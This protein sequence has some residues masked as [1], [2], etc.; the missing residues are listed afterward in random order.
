MKQLTLNFQTGME[1]TGEM[2]TSS[3][4][5]GSLDHASHSAQQ[6]NETERE[7]IATSG[8]KCY[9]S[10]ERLNRPGLLAKTLLASSRWTAGLYS[11]KYALRWK[12]KGTPSKRLYCQ[13]SVRERRTDGIGY[14]LLP[15]MSAS[16]DGRNVSTETHEWTGVYFKSKNGKKVQSDVRHIIENLYLLPTPKAADGEKGKGGPNGH[17]QTLGKAIEG[18]NGANTGMKLQPAFVEYLMG[19]P[20]GWTDLSGSKPSETP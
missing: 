6:E 7:M 3:S 1:P 4:P 15:T 12:L 18:T 19:Y 8:Q 9:G 5:V 2:T 14:G 20:E 13:L 10:L 11:R 17:T 16:G